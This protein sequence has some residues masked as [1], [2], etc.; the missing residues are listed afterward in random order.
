MK[1]L[2]RT[3]TVEKPL[4]RVWAYLTD[5]THTEEWDPP[6]MSTVRTAG[7]GG[8]GTV[9]HN[10]SKSGGKNVEIDYTVIAYEP[11][12]RF[13]LRGDNPSV[14]M[15]DTITF[16]ESDGTVV[17]TYHVDFEPHGAAKLAE[18]LMPLALKRL[19]DS[20]GDSMLEHLQTL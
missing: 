7:D 16:E 18:P 2:E 4:D 14:T 1:S 5:F 10:V 20:A 17:I 8:L 15:T 3:L 12:R 9:Y 11:Q 13:Q 19:G 6:T